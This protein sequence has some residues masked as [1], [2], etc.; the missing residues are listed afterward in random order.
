MLTVCAFLIGVPHRNGKRHVTEMA[1][2]SLAICSGVS[3][4]HVPHLPDHI[5][6]LRIGI[7]TGKMVAF[8][9]GARVIMDEKKKKQTNKQ[10]KHKVWSDKA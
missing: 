1:K 10:T 2:L 7:H 5:F 6:Q 9:Q 4:V 8:I 3:E